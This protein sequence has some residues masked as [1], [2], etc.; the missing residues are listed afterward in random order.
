MIKILSFAILLAVG[1]QCYGQKGLYFGVDIGLSISHSRL[2]SGKYHPYPVTS[3]NFKKRGRESLAL[4]GRVE[5]GFN[6]RI[7]LVGEI[8]SATLGH[9]Y[10]FR[11]IRLEEHPDGRKSYIG[12]SIKVVGFSPITFSLL[13]KH[14]TKIT[15]KIFFSHSFGVGY[16][17]NNNYGT[18]YSN[19]SYKGIDKLEVSNTVYTLNLHNLCIINK[20]GL[21]YNI[22]KSNYLF[23]D[24]VLNIGT[25]DIEKLIV[26]YTLNGE[27]YY[28]EI[29]SKGDYFNLVIG[30]K[31]LFPKFKNKKLK[32]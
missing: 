22:S 8:R 6:D 1:F 5:Y 12:K 16:M 4:S 25:R 18:T 28:N 29:I 15:E 21:E 7:G 26:D 27:H 23:L 24:A 10:Q 31:F 3:D 17:K 14:R 9:G 11:N 2:E 20:L 30:Y 32:E 19:K 13:L